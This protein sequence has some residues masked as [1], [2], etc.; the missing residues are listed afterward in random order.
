MACLASVHCHDVLVAVFA[1]TTVYHSRSRTALELDAKV[2]RV[3]VCKV[4][5]PLLLFRLWVSSTSEEYL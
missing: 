2:S 5:T 1:A 4:S 3:G